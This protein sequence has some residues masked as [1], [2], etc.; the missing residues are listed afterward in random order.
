MTESKQRVRPI[1]E[2]DHRWLVSGI[3]YLFAVDA[4][5]PD[6]RRRLMALRKHVSERVSEALDWQSPKPR[7]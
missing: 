2:D 6:R 5:T 3:K 4:E 7:V 1:T